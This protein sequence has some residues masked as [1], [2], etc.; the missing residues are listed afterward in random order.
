VGGEIWVM[1]AVFAGSGMRYGDLDEMYDVV[2]MYVGWMDG[3]ICMMDATMCTMDGT[4][5]TMDGT[6]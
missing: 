2:D 4:I 3:T 1:C 6:V 5:C